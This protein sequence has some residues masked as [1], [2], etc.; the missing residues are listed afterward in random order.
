MIRKNL[1]NIFSSLAFIGKNYQQIQPWDTV[2]AGKTT[3]TT[4]Q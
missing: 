3:I 2:I 1:E 4:M